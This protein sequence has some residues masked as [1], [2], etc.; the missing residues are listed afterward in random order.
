M[1]KLRDKLI[2]SLCKELYR[3]Q[4]LEL[5]KSELTELFERGMLLAEGKEDGFLDKENL[6][7]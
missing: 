2:F 7:L 5:E 6:N 4:L 3:F 1:C